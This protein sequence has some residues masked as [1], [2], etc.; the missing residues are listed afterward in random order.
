MRLT[1]NKTYWQFLLETY[2]I[3]YIDFACLKYY[4]RVHCWNTFPGRPSTQRC[5]SEIE[6]AQ[7][8]LNGKK[9]IRKFFNVENAIREY[10]QDLHHDTFIMKT[11]RRRPTSLSVKSFNLKHVQHYNRAIKNKIKTIFGSN[12]IGNKEKKTIYYSL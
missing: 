9:K 6:T 3:L 7:F 1:L 8:K 10:L 5:T 12:I 11:L 4:V 2:D